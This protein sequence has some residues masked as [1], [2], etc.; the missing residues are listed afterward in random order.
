ME[1]DLDLDMIKEIAPGAQVISYEAP[2]SGKVSQGDIIN[3]IVKDRRASVISDSWGSCEER[4]LDSRGGRALIRSDFATLAMAARTGHTI[5][6][7]SGDTGAYSCHDRDPED[8]RLSV[9]WPAASSSVVAVGGTYLQLTSA[10]RRFLEAAWSGSQSGAGTGGGLSHAVARP[11]YQS[12]PG[13]AN[14]F[15]NGSRQLP[16]VVGPADPHWG[17][18]PVLVPRGFPGSGRRDERGDAVWAASLA[19]VR[20]YAAQRRRPGSRGRR[21]ARFST[22]SPR[23]PR[24]AH[25]TT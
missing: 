10:G 11:T 22:E 17:G 18:I 14:R 9:D 13:V 16:D 3:R 6:V 19:L 1:V 15:S 25:S 2:N 4:L 5:F 12:G 21:R 24:T 8:N 23:T 20:Q 7:V